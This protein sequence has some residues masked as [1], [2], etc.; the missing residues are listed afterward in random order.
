VAGPWRGDGMSN[1]LASLEKQE[2]KGV[3]HGRVWVFATSS[4]DG[5]AD[6]RRAAHTSGSPS[7][8]APV[9]R[10]A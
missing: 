1:L 9:A 6:K 4:G 8:R 3:V 5:W 10:G 7:R 2:D